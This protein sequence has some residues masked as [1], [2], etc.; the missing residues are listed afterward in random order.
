MFWSDHRAT[1]FTFLKK[2]EPTNDLQSIQQ[3]N[4]YRLSKI[5]QIVI[6]EIDATKLLKKMKAI[7]VN[8]NIFKTEALPLA[9]V[10]NIHVTIS[11]P[12]R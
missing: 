1:V 8:C 9:Y 6:T 5:L 2:N 7:I 12:S 10:E 4:I 3:I 11:V